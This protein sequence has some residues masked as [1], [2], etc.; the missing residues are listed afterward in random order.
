VKELRVRLEAELKMREASEVELTE[1]R[2]GR[3][4]GA[5]DPIELA[6]E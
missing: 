3:V 5:G 4:A 1:E 6:L 2:I